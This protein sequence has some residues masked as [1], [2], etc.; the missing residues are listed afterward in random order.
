MADPYDEDDDYELEL[1]DVDAEVLEHARV[2]ATRQVEETEA[3]AARLETFDVPTEAEAIG[4]DD[5]KSF[6]FTTWHLLVATALVAVFMSVIKLGGGCNGIFI[7][8]LMTLAAGWWYVL[9]K[10]RNERLA[11]ERRRLE[12]EARLEKSRKKETVV[13]ERMAG[14]EP[15]E[16]EFVPTKPALSFSFSL[17]QILGTFAVAAVVLTIATLFGPNTASLVLGIVA[18]LGLAIQVIGIELPGIL[19]FGWWILML[20]YVA[21]SLW[22]VFSSAGGP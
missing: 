8:G 2:R 4:L 1:E 6:R 15:V 22:A 21:M 19:V 16:E 13:T 11:R 17:K 20:M 12:I 10:E 18:V 9:R 14:L 3:R 5:L 7:A